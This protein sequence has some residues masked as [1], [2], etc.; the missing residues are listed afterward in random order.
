MCTRRYRGNVYYFC[1]AAPSPYRYI[2]SIKLS[3]SSALILVVPS[4]SSRLRKN[5]ASS[6]CCFSSFRMV[7]SKDFF[8]SSQLGADQTVS[9][10]WLTEKGY[11]CYKQC[12]I[13]F[14]NQRSS[15]RNQKIGC[16]YGKT[17]LKPEVDFQFAITI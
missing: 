15:N 12:G 7:C 4:S 1:N 16:R 13:S 3:A 14:Q 17:P 11:V 6:F 8:L 2:L 9:V 10:I 5:L